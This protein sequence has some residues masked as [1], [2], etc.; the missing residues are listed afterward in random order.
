MKVFPSS[1]QATF[2]ANYPEVPHRLEHRLQAHP[3]LELDALADLARRLP[4]EFIECNLGNQPIGV[5]RVPD[6]LRERAVETIMDIGRAGC[7][8][9]LRNVEQQPEY[10]KLLADLL[11][12]VRPQIERKTG[13]MMN[14]QSFIFVTSPGGVTPYHFDP[15]HNILLQLRGS[16]VMTVFAAGEPACA[17]D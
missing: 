17:A 12:D 5:D 9:G 11:E 8:V 14:L 15:E 1:A 16:K 4:A 6:Q 2:A 3:L 7:W 13:P 10:A